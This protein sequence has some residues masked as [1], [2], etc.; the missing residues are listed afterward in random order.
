MIEPT[1][2]SLLMFNWLIL[3]A[4][5]AGRRAASKTNKSN[6]VPRKVSNAGSGLGGEDSQI[7][8]VNIGAGS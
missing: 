5:S 4:D 3:R 7:G 8:I 1:I 2:E 6:T